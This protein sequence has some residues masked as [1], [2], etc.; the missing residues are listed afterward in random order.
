MLA[1]FRRPS[2]AT[3]V[4]YLAL[5]FAIG[6]GGFAVAS[7]LRVNTSDIVDEAVRNAKLGDNSVNGAKVKNESLTGQDLA[8]NSVGSPRITDGSL[9]GQDIALN[10]VGSTRI[11][12]GSLSS[13]DIAPNSIASGRVL[14]NTL[15]GADINESTLSG[16]RL[17]GVQIVSSLTDTNS[18]SPKN[19]SVH[20]PAGKRVIGVGYHVFEDISGFFPDATRDVVV[21]AATPSDED[22]AFA[23]ATENDPVSGAWSLSLRAICANAEPE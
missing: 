3:V 8:L 17:S 22:S 2:H 15:T 10:S 1:R 16:V 7:H 23:S 20:C 9:T 21:N 18:N 11:T 4:A 5:F 6:G 12:D 14:D 13:V 19:T